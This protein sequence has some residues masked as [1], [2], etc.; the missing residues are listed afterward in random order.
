[1]IFHN[2]KIKNVDKNLQFLIEVYVFVHNLK[3]QLT[4]HKKKLSNSMK[5]NVDMTNDLS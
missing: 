2:C 4:L 1:M 5:I 3:I